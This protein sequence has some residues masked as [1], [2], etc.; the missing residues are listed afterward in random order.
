MSPT[1]AR[2]PPCENVLAWNEYLYREEDRRWPVVVYL[3]GCILLL[4]LGI[5][6]VVV[7]DRQRTTELTTMLNNAVVVVQ[8]ILQHY[9]PTTSDGLVQQRK[10]VVADSGYGPVGIM[11]QQYNNDNMSSLYSQ[12]MEIYK[13]YTT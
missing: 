6:C 5:A 10:H 13:R 9:I 12:L 1:I 2:L 8:D 11:Y 3:L 4:V 7:V